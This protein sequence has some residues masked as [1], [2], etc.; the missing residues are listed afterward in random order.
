MNFC[1]RPRVREAVTML[2]AT[3]TFFPCRLVQHFDTFV[4]ESDIQTLYE[5]VCRLCVSSSLSA[6]GTDAN[7]RALPR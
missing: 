1:P 4:T 5:N 2:T 6:R 7:L 3:C